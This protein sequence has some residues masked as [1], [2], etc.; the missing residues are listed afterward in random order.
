MGNNRTPTA[1]AACREKEF[2]PLNKSHAKKRIYFGGDLG[3]K[4]SLF[5]S[6]ISLQI[7]SDIITFLP[8]EYVLDAS[9]PGTFKTEFLI[10]NITGEVNIL[11]HMTAVPYDIQS[12]L[13]FFEGK[14]LFY[15]T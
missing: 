10:W 8:S 1:L 11:F 6:L 12:M 9:K 4:S 14:F 7:S 2:E 15:G 3:R 5:M 13:T